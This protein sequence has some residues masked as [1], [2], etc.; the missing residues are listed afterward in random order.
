MN[1]EKSSQSKRTDTCRP[2]ERLR[3]C[4]TERKYLKEVSVAEMKRFIGVYFWMGAMDQR[5]IRDHSQKQY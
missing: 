4:K 3:M 1:S 2:R 5:K